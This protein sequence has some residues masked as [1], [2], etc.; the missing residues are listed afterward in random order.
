MY[1]WVYVCMPTHVDVCMCRWMSAAVKSSKRGIDDV[2]SLKSEM[3]TITRYTDK[4]LTSI[5]VE[6]NGFSQKEEHKSRKIH[7]SV[8]K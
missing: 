6:E 1:A 7:K 3:K 4:K 5:G 2:T 8:L